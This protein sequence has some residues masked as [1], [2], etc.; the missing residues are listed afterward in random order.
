LQYQILSTR[1]FRKVTAIKHPEDLFEIIKRYARSKQE[2]L[3]VITLNGAHEVICVHMATIGLINRNVIHP[4]E[5]FIHTV[6]DCAVSFAIAHNHPS[7]NVSPSLQDVTITDRIN[8]AAKIMGFNFLD[9]LIISKNKFYSFRREHY[10][11]RDDY[12]TNDIID[13]DFIES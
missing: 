4:R 9:H 10:L 12:L 1:K 5:I 8:K 13:K 7:G 6:Q 11:L 2:I 3:L